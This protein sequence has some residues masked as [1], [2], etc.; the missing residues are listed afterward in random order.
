VDLQIDWAWGDV[1]VNSVVSYV[2]KFEVQ[3]E[4]GSAWLDYAGSVGSPSVSLPG[5]IPTWKAAT[6]VQYRIG[7]AA[8]GA[9]WRFIDNMQS[10]SKVTNPS[11]T[12]PEVS[13]IS[14]LDL[15]GAWQATDIV[16]VRGGINNVTDKNPPL[17]GTRPGSTQA[18]TYDIFGRQYYVGLSLN[19]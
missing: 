16:T 12:V 8:L 10:A 2:D 3:L 9:K 19:F 5:S 4:K 1:S 14:Y 17:V 18:S 11:S 7:D 15:Y 6:R 13:A